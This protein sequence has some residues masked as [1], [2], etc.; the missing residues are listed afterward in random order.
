MMTA[1]DFPVT[2]AESALRSAEARVA[3]LRQQIR[4]AE[5]ELHDA[6]READEAKL[7]LLR[8]EAAADSDAIAP[9]TPVRHSMFHDVRGVVVESDGTGIAVLQ[10]SATE[11]TY[12]FNAREWKP[13]R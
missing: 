13:I 1:N 9:G 3:A 4:E 2:A 11:P 8:A 12:G 5:R 10:D 7:A 6:E